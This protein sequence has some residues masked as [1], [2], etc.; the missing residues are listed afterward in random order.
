MER[1]R[2]C[3][4]D[5]QYMAD[6]SFID[7]LHQARTSIIFKRY[8]GQKHP[9]SVLTMIYAI[10][11][12]LS[13]NNRPSYIHRLLELTPD[14]QG[15]TIRKETHSSDIIFSIYIH[16]YLHSIERFLVLK[17]FLIKNSNNVQVSVQEVRLQ[18]ATREDNQQMVCK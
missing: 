13:V 1:Y 8:L 6:I 17:I 15:R 11:T 4:I 12:P 7:E 5:I 2:K 10:S 14:Y 18:R 9:R 16:V 3:I